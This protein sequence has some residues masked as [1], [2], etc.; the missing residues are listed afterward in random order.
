MKINNGMKTKKQLF[1]RGINFVVQTNKPKLVLL[2][3][4]ET[5]AMKI[6]L[7]AKKKRLSGRLKTFWVSILAENQKTVKVM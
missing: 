5:K 1:R 2:K 4:A 3:D 6:P 7:E